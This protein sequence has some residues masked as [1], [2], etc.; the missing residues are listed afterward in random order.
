MPRRK[1]KAA[2]A[3]SPLAGEII[4]IKVWL[5]G[6]SPMIWRRLHVP[7]SITL[8]ELHGVL[9]VAMGWES[10]HLFQ[11][12]LRAIGFGSWE[13]SARSPD[14]TLEEL[15]LR[16]GA[17]FVYEYDLNIP[18]RHELRLE[19]RLDPVP[20]RAYPYC[21]DGHEACPPED[22]GGPAAHL[23]QRDAWHSMD[24]L[25]DLAAMAKIIKQV[26]LERRP[27]L[28]DRARVRE[29]WKGNP[30]S[31]REVNARLRKGEHLVFTNQHY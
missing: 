6:I 12:Q 1:G 30:F 4:Q 7:A 3:G 14:I 26:V 8:R 11:F 21:A 19:E 29:A 2:T 9:Q 27:E 24:A 18:W 17:R 28:L 13:L 15:R 20:R 31:R 5:M 25:G 10:W 16:K 23:V 22:C